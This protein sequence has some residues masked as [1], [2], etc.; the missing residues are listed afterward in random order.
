MPRHPQRRPGTAAFTKGSTGGITLQAGQGLRPEPQ[1]QAAHRGGQGTGQQAREPSQGQG[2]R[3]ALHEEALAPSPASTDAVV[4][5]GCRGCSRTFGSRQGLPR[6]LRGLGHAAVGHRRPASPSRQ[7]EPSPSPAD[8]RRPRRPCHPR[9]ISSGHQRYP[10]DRH[11]HSAWTVHQDRPL[12]TWRSGAARNCMACGGQAMRPY[13]ARPVDS[14][15]THGGPERRMR[16]VSPLVLVSS[17]NAAH[18]PWRLCPV[19]E[20]IRTPSLVASSCRSRPAARW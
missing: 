10:A 7:L 19:A 16:T 3:T 17:P 8:H 11:G 9:A 5:D 6:A 18:E 12:L 20:A 14:A 15:P 2:V 4:V 13:P 1:G